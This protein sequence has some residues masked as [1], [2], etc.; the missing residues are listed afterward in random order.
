MS[1]LNVPPPE[2][3]NE[4]KTKETNNNINKVNSSNN[5][6]AV[7]LSSKRMNSPKL[8]IEEHM[9]KKSSTYNLGEGV[10]FFAENNL[11]KIVKEKNDMYQKAKTCK[12][13][14]RHKI[15]INNNQ[16]IEGD[17]NHLATINEVSNSKVDSSEISDDSKNNSKEKQSVMYTK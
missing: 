17:V 8:E 1:E 4:T 16:P 7:N 14:N 3:V 10:A 6:I 2:S 15:N 13:E 12:V 5:N 11:I 9:Y